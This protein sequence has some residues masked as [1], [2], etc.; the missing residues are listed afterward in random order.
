MLL[1]IVMVTMVVQWVVYDILDTRGKAHLKLAV[2]VFLLLL[3]LVIIPFFLIDWFVPSR[4][5]G[6]NCGLPFM[7]FVLASWVLGAGGTTILHL[8]YIFK[9]R[10]P[11]S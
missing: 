11:S 10:I 8:V 2:F 1:P 6:L 3:F 9:N 5:D 7:G 4:A